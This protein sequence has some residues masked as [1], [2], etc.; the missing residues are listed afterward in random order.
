MSSLTSSLQLRKV[1]TASRP[2]KKAV[3]A[4]DDEITANPGA[5][6]ARLRVAEKI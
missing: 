2:Q 5:R 4:S 6:S 3:K 1:K